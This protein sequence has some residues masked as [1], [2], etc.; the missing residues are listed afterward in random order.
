[1]E[2]DRIWKGY[3]AVLATVALWLSF[4]LARVFLATTEK[5]A[6]DPNYL[7]VSFVLAKPEYMVGE[8]VECACLV[9]NPTNKDRVYTEVN[10]A[11]GMRLEL[12]AAPS[13]S[14]LRQPYTSSS[15][16]SVHKAL[17]PGQ[18]TNRSFLLNPFVWFTKPGTYTLRLKQWMGHRDITS[19]TN[20]SRGVAQQTLTVKC[21]PMD[22]QRFHAAMHALVQKALH[23]NGHERALATYDLGVIALPETL[24]YWK[25][26]LIA[27]DYD[28]REDMAN[29]LADLGGEEAA[30]LL[31]SVQANAKQDISRRIAENALRKLQ[32][33]AESRKPSR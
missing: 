21:H 27:S 14:G 32:N 16:L 20:W 23:G 10:P 12:L 24:P 11:N 8:P 6:L 3:V 1:M 2:N 18:V 19:P 29:G 13:G 28:L 17:E 7:Q 26:Y 25:E 22:L 4:E 9:R 15:V 31:K 30:A 33:L 5:P